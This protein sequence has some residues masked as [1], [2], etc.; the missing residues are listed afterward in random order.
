MSAKDM[1]HFSMASQYCAWV[2][3]DDYLWR[4]LAETLSFH[5]KHNHET[6]KQSYKRCARIELNQDTD[7]ATKRFNFDMCP[8][9][10]FKTHVVKLLDCYSNF[11][12]AVDAQGIF[13]VFLIDE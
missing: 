7:R 2:A 11:V 4:Y 12:L 1:L 13:A 10:H 3:K 6:W 8:I 5:D 9:R